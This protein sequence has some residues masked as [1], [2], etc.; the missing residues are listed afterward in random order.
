MHTERT[1]GCAHTQCG[2]GARFPWLPPVRMSSCSARP[3][4][5]RTGAGR[6]GGGEHSRV[7]E[8]RGACRGW[9]H[10]RS[11]PRSPSQRPQSL[12][13][14]GRRHLR[15]PFARAG[16]EQQGGGAVS[17]VAI[18]P[19]PPPRSRATLAWVSGTQGAGCATRPG[20]RAP[21]EARTMPPFMYK[22]GRD[23]EGSGGG[24]C[25]RCPL[26]PERGR[27]REA[28]AYLCAPHYTPRLCTMRGAARKGRG[29]PL[30]TARATLRRSPL[31]PPSPGRALAF[32]A[33]KAWWRE[34]ARSLATSPT[35]RPI[36]AP[37]PRAN[38]VGVEV[39]VGAL[40]SRA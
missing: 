25:A 1:R 10:A 16:R 32:R 39:G 17:Q 22:R 8:G 15:T 27:G 18:H 11:H 6:K 35:R 24:S 2:R 37:S 30:G 14:W 29:R 19:H 9:L 5:T 28:R 12:L 31:P 33:G 38:G 36:P 21:V 26:R 7:N 3:L 23:Q 20:F 34:G 13:E 40:R 4:C